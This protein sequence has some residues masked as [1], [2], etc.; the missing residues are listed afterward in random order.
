[1]PDLS[2]N[3]EPV[4]TA[5]SSAAPEVGPG[6]V[7]RSWLPLSGPAAFALAAT[8][9]GIVVLLTYGWTLRAP[10]IFDDVACIV[11]NASIMHVFPLW[12][13]G[14]GSGPLWPPQ[15]FTT[16][17]RPLVNL[18]LAI[19][20][21]FDGL[22]PLGFHIFN[23]V[24]HWLAAMLLWAI[25]RRTLLLPYYEG[26]FTRSADLLALCVALLWAV[27]PLQTEAVQ[28]VSQRT[29]LMM[30]VFYLSTLYC[31][32]RYWTTATEG[33]RVGWPL[34]AA[35]SCLAGMACKEVMVTAPVVVLLYE[36][37]FVTGSLLTSL[38]R[39]WPL[40][41]GLS[42]GWI[43]LIALNIHGPRSAS[44]G[45]HLGVSPIAYWC[46]QC[47]VLLLYLKLAV[48]PWP[49]VI[50]YGIP[51]YDSFSAAWP[52]V[53]TVGLLA[54]GTL[55][56]LWRNSP[57]GFLFAVVWLVL[58]PTL[59]VPVVSE[60]AAERR[61]YIPLAAL[62]AFVVVEVYDAL[63]KLFS[64]RP[65]R[66][67][68]RLS[69][70]RAAVVLS[71][72]TLAATLTL[73]LVSVRRLSA[74]R[75][76]LTLW[77]D[78]QRHQPDN[79]VVHTNLGVEYIN[80]G[81]YAEAIDELRKADQLA[82]DNRPKIHTELATAL[83]REGRF[84]EAVKEFRALLTLDPT[85]YE[86]DRVRDSLAVSLVHAGQVEEG[87]AEFEKI[88]RDHPDSAEAHNNYGLALLKLDR[89][90]D[91]IA[92]FQHAA[93]LR[94]GSPQAYANLG[95]ALLEDGQTRAAIK[96]FESALRLQPIYPLVHKSL[97]RAFVESEQP[98]AAIPQLEK[99]RASE[100][101]SSQIEFDLGR[102]LAGVG[103]WR[104]AVAH[105]KRAQELGEASSTMQ[106]EYGIALAQI[107]RPEEAIVRFE[108]ALAED[109]Q[110]SAAWFALAKAKAT[111]RQRSEAIAAAE[112]ASEIA[113]GQD[114]AVLADQVD[115][116]LSAYRERKGP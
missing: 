29:E 53:L 111:L 66:Q 59:V 48:W 65:E 64:S 82:T 42:L 54:A 45:F 58:S 24:T 86:Y 67:S 89:T 3:S 97:G 78:A 95:S 17:G 112:R 44:A 114:L 56:L 72:L 109:Q 74:Y 100:P 28:Y 40:H 43:L 27:H 105:Y 85:S 51:F 41:A 50:H 106:R 38:R 11:N 12:D 33:G 47:E 104:D 10:F 75:E 110:D 108:Q 99:A 103:R 16:A 36:R 37:T 23:L 21:A 69:V 87:V 49:L 61:M 52:R 19:N 15:D 94:P 26:R 102:A 92:Q 5:G 84:E 31:A 73:S 14:P 68:R 76:A 32:I 55:W 77:H 13:E 70:G 34:L 107:A 79:Y 9:L 30:A 81:R 39:S 18:S 90:K 1:M 60:V 8:I 46:T 88:V 93:R 63:V 98:S 91:A 2:E 71:L 7:D 20:V 6:T 116:W 4:A 25:G 35:I 57:A 62:C 101:E 115:S 113:H 80:A 22:N 96:Q 83:A